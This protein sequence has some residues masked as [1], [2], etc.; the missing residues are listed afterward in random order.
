MGTIDFSCEVRAAA[1]ELEGDPGSNK[2]CFVLRGSS[3]LVLSENQPC[4]TSKQYRKGLL[5]KNQ[6]REMLWHK[7]Q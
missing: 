7:L 4:R 6:E 5:N 3:V 2:T 1:M